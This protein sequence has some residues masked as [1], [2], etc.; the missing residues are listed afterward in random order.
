MTH[1]GTLFVVSAPSGAGKRTVLERV[2]ARDTRLT[3]AVSATTR[4]PRP[5]EVDGT[6]Y[7]FLDETAFRRRI[8]DGGFAEWAEVHGNL[9]GTPRGELSR[10]LGSGKDVVLELDVQGMRAI[11]AQHPG[12]VTVFIAPPCFDELE[13]RLRARGLNDEASMAVRL[14]N[15]RAEMDAQDEYDYV[16]V[17]EVVE[18]AAEDLLAIVQAARRPSAGGA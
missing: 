9:Y 15:A 7:V 11:K 4:R 17:N 6:D 5:G 12:A 10:R 18:D 16:V 8:D 2:L 1:R 14:E 13:R 3:Y